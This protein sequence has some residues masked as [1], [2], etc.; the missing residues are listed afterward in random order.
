M[1]G[2][3]ILFTFPSERNI[4]RDLTKIPD[5]CVQRYWV[6][7]IDDTW[8]GYKP[9]YKNLTR[10]ITSALINDYPIVRT[11]RCH[12]LYSVKSTKKIIMFV[13]KW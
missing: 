11:A 10:K 12:T 4:Q 13:F 1:Y 6:K 3:N 8:R 5:P 9:I 2:R 7:R